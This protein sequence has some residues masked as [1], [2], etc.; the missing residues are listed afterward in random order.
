MIRA[1]LLLVPVSLAD[2]HQVPGA[3]QLLPVEAELEM[4][5]TV[6]G[7]GIA[8][9]A[10][11]I[12]GAAVPEQHRAAAVLPL[13]DDPLEAAVLHRVVLDVDGEALLAG[14]EA[15]P[16]GDGP[17]P[18]HPFHL[19]AEVV[20]Q[21]GGGVLLDD[22]GQRAGRAPFRRVARGLSRN[23]EVP[24]A[25][26]FGEPHAPMLITSPMRL[27]RTLVPTLKEAPSEAEVPSHVFMVRGGYLRKV[28]AGV[29]SFL[30]LGKRVLEKVERIIR[31]EMVRAG[32]SEVQLPTTIPAELWQESGRWEKY[33]DQLLRFKDRKGGDF[34]IG[35]THEEVIS[36]LVRGEVRSWRQLPLNLYQI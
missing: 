32:A 27:S 11:R 19:E 9:R 30:P 36:A 10:L 35:P 4:A 23:R 2:A 17:A 12:P 6:G 34:V 18:Q 8:F 25:V 5:L 20:V 28:A 21:A 3:L 15:R 13:G 7:H 31:E 29:Y 24:L 16:L 26:V 1:V 33:G 14:I 22:E